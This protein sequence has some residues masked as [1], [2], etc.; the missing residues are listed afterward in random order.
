MIVRSLACGIAV[1]RMGAAPHRPRV[2]PVTKPDLS[3]PAD[4]GDRPV[5]GRRAD[6]MREI[7]EAANWLPVT[8][9]TTK[10]LSPSP[11]CTCSGSTGSARPMIRKVTKTTPMIGNSATIERLRGV[12]EQPR[13]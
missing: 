13:V 10:V 12:V 8:R 3:E 7:S 9:P 5:P 11:R 6:Q 1:R 2:R 4:Q